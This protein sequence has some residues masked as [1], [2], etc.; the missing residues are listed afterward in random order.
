[1]KRFSDMRRAVK[2][3]R[4]RRSKLKKLE[5]RVERAERRV[6]EYVAAGWEEF[7]RVVDILVE[8]GALDD[9]VDE[10]ALRA[11]DAEAEAEARGARETS[12]AAASAD[13]IAGLLD[14]EPD[15]PSRPF[16][17]EALGDAQYLGGERLSESG[18]YSE[19]ERN[20]SYASGDSRR[21]DPYAAERRAR[22]LRRAARW[23]DGD[24][25]MD[26]VLALTPLGE[27]MRPRR[28]RT[29]FGSASLSRRTRSKV[30]GRNR[31]RAS[32]ARCAAT[33]TDRRRARTDRR[34][35]WT[36]RSRRSNRTPA[37]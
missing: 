9:V 34:P 12:N 10:D 6:G 31:S 2:L 3:N 11:I 21:V 26:A 33:P 27:A 17:L 7:T 16:S 15:D 24:D 30:S 22:D 8:E 14:W 5:T 4:R 20:D 13:P 32:P 18:S 19:R 29:N 35:N 23:R 1:M 37:S 25:R 28:G 36:S